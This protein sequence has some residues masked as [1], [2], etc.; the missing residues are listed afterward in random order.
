MG[1]YRLMYLC[2]VYTTKRQGWI[3]HGIKGPES[4]ADHMYCI[5]SMVLFYGDLPGGFLE[6]TCG[7]LSS[8][9]LSRKSMRVFTLLYKGR[10]LGFHQTGKSWVINEKRETEIQFAIRLNHILSSEETRSRMALDIGLTLLVETV[11]NTKLQPWG[12]AY[13]CF[14]PH[15]NRLKISI[16]HDIAEA[17]VGDATPS[18]GVPKQEK[19]QVYGS[20]SFLSIDSLAI[21]MCGDDE[22]QDSIQINVFHECH[23]SSSTFELL[24]I[25]LL[26]KLKEAVSDGHDVLRV[27]GIIK[28]KIKML[29]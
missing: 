3:N 1:A 7:L 14:C 15:C 24:M 10:F 25:S 27:T 18:D 17:T 28:K 23:L 19:K 20:K 9:A 21:A 11:S 13:D 2:L 29:K 26:E 5:S 16:V 22:T 4:I 6:K 12:F 8:C